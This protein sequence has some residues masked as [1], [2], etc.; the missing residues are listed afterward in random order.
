[1]ADYPE[2]R[3]PMTGW[4]QV[5]Q[6]LLPETVF[7]QNEAVCGR[8]S[9][10]FV[11]EKRLS[12][13]ELCLR[14]GDRLLISFS[15]NDEKEDPLRYTSPRMTFPEYLNMFIDAARRQGA[16]PVLITPIARRL[17]GGDGHPVPPKARKERN[18]YSVTSPPDIRIILKVWRTTA[19]FSCA[20]QSG[21]RRSSCGRM[22]VR[23]SL[24]NVLSSLRPLPP[25]CSRS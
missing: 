3:A 25:A 6:A 24:L 15:H 12:L 8:S 13:I 23:P 18:R 21:S 19:I 16:E 17:F 5:L 7:V 11:A 1:M 22:N 9:K 14:P 10:S 2:D 4:G 20:V